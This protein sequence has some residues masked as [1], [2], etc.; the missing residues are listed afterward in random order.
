MEAKLKKLRK[1]HTTRKLISGENE[2]LM[3]K[4]FWDAL[5]ENSPKALKEFKVFI[6]LRYYYFHTEDYLSAGGTWS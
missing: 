1:R 6:H 5:T 4:E 3:F 2:R